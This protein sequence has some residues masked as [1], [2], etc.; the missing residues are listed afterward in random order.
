MKLRSLIA[1]ALALVCASPALAQVTPGTAP[2]TGQKG[3]TGNGFMQFSGPASSLKTYTLPNASGTIA[4]LG[5][6][7]TWTAAQT[8][9]AAMTYGGITLSNSVTGTGSMVLSTSPTLVTPALG[10]PSSVSLANATGLPTTGLTGILQ[11]GQFPALTGDVTTS[12]GALAATIAAN[13]V[14]NAKMATMAANTIK[15]NNTGSPATPIDL[16]GA[17]AGAILCAPNRQ[18]FTS[19]T[20]TTYTTPT[21]N[22]ALPTRIELEMVGGGGGGSGSGTTPSGQ[23]AGGNSCWNTSSPACTSPLFVAN[24]GSFGSITAGNFSLGGTA[25]GCDLNLTGMG[26]GETTSATNHDGGPGGISFFGGGGV[27]GAVAGVAQAGQA[28]VTNTGS[29]GG[30]AS[31]LATANNGGGG[32][33]GGYCRKLIASPASSYFY[34]V[35]AGG[36]LGSAGTSGA[37]GG[38][39]A[40]GLILATAY[41]Q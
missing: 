17:Q 30:G 5:Q 22:G 21:C 20:N 4:L 33:A 23:T 38:A 28:A 12:A 2:L 10:T 32:A 26:G 1:L 13:A 9:S 29:G 3:G 7:Q 24:G 14:T 40:A 18:V 27:P 39:G 36:T 34:T 37:A 11:A 35:G 16:T 19:G 31:D 41:W 8:F 25:S 15:G 6:I